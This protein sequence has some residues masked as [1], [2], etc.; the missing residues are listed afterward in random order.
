M[1]KQLKK[2]LE[3]EY[4][5]KAQILDDRTVEVQAQDGELFQFISNVA[6]YESEETRL[7]Y[8]HLFEMAF[9]KHFCD[10]KEMMSNS[11]WRELNLLGV[12]FMGM[13]AGNRHRERVRIGGQ[14]RQLRQGKGMEARDLALL[15]GIDAANLSRIEQG[16][17][18]VG[19]D[20]LSRIAFVLGAHIDLV[21]NQVV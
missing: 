7:Y 12:P 9:D 3:T 16:K 11:I 17:Y 19:L 20:I 21:P 8:L 10:D 15:A 13:S 18:S 2:F 4:K 1:D 6:R 14:I 5:S